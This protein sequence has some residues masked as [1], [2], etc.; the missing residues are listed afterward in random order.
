MEATT[1]TECREISSYD[2]APVQPN[3]A[4]TK[5]RTFGYTGDV[6]AIEYRYYMLDE[7]REHHIGLSW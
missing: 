7:F 3:S 5:F 6:E 2:I 4:E 1:R